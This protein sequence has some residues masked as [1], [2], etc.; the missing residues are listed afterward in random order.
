MINNTSSLTSSKLF[1][2]PVLDMRIIA[3]RMTQAITTIVSKMFQQ[4][5]LM[6]LFRPTN[7][8]LQTK[9]MIMSK[10]IMHSAIINKGDS[11]IRKPLNSVIRTKNKVA[12]MSPI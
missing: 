1:I 12:A 11:S 9:S 8:T 3:K 4:P 10:L 6:N 5:P 2:P 7:L